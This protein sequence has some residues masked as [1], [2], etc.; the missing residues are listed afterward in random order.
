VVQ[1]CNW[2]REAA[3]EVIDLGLAGDEA[4]RSFAYRFRAKLAGSA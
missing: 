3:F 4:K 2:A 1:V